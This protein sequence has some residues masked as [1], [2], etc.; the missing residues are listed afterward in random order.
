MTDPKLMLISGAGL[1]SLLLGR[2]LS[3]HGIPFKIFE[4]DGGMDNR[5]QGYRLRLADEALDA[6]ESVLDSSSFERFFEI[7]G[8]TGGSG[9]QQYNAVTGELVEHPVAE[10]LSSRESKVVG[11]ARGDLRT[12][13]GL[14]GA[15]SLG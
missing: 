6:I 7:S 5:R 8:K 14:R 10:T 11:V 13:A 1:A 15:C 2:A 9:F 12:Y 4:R 3:R